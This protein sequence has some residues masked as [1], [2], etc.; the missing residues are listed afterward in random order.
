MYEY[1]YEVRVYGYIDQEHRNQYPEGDR[2]ENLRIQ[3][4][5]NTATTFIIAIDINIITGVDA[6]ILAIFLTRIATSIPQNVS[7]QNIPD[8]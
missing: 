3:V 7:Q 6:T 4:Y 5:Q 8:E 2:L 1:R